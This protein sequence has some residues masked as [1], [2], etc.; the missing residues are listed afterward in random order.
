[1]AFGIFSASTPL[2]TAEG[3]GTTD[4]ETGDDGVP[5]VLLLAVPLDGAVERRKETTPDTE[6]AAEDGG[7]R[8][9]GRERT[10][11]TLA[12]GSAGAYR[13]ERSLAE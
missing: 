11:E 4:A 6:V 12:L 2:L 7:T 13:G 8:L 10:G 1:L 5:G 9:D 3:K